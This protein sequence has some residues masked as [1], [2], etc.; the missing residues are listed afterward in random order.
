ML[1]RRRGARLGCRA[2]RL[3]ASGGASNP[4]V[5]VVTWHRA[6]AALGVADADVS[7]VAAT[8]GAASPPSGG[9]EVTGSREKRYWGT[10]YAAAPT[11]AQGQNKAQFGPERRRRYVYPRASFDRQEGATARRLAS[12]GQLRYPTGC[13]T[14]AGT[15]QAFTQVVHDRIVIRCL[16]PM[17]CEEAPEVSW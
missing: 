9:R 1:G 16:R 7:A 17:A 10:K 5:H 12:S 6:S 13:Q 11:P 4:R 14:G 15:S 2:T 3:G 8:T